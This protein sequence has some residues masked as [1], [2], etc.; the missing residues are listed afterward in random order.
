MIEMKIIEPSMS[1]WSSSIALVQKISRDGSV[2]SRF[3]V[4]YR[5]LNAMTKPDAYPIPNMTDTLDSGHSK[6]FTVLDMASR[7][8]RIPIKTEHKKTVFSCHR[9]NFVY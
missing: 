8:H 7:Y 3:C 6:L 9:G 4:D 1:P 5:A 2:K